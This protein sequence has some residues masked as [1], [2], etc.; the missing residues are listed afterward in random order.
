VAFDIPLTEFA[1]EVAL[2]MSDD[3]DA[4]GE[5]WKKLPEWSR[6]PQALEDAMRGHR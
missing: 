2:A 1:S 6:E 3:H 5:A 4:Q